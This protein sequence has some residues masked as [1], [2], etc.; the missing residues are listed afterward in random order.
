MSVVWADELP[1]YFALRIYYEY[2]WYCEFTTVNVVGLHNRG[3]TR[4]VEHRK[5]YPYP[6]CDG[7]G[8]GQIVHADGQNF[9]VLRFELV[10]FSLQ[11]T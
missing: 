11:I 10:V 4:S 3:I 5:C 1:C 9:G 8:A 6:T 2:G 7:I